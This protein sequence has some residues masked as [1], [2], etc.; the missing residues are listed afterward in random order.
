MPIPTLED[1][2]EN[3]AVLRDDIEHLEARSQG[4]KCELSQ[5]SVER[6]LNV[7]YRLLQEQR[8]MLERAESSS[9]YEAAQARWKQREADD[10]LDLY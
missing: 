7:K 10:T 6:V 1:L 8:D 3:V 5:D 2:R 4:I 9:A